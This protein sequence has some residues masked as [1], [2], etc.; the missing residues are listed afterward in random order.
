MNENYKRVFVAL[1]DQFGDQGI[2]WAAQKVAGHFTASPAALAADSD[3]DANPDSSPDANAPHDES[4]F[5]AP[6]D[7]AR[8]LDGDAFV[9]DTERSV[10]G[11]AADAINSPQQV[12]D[13]VMR[14]VMIAGE[15]RKF[16]EAQVTKRLS[17]AADRDVAIAQLKA[18]HQLLQDYL[19]RS[20]D[21]RA[22]NFTKLFAVVD[23]ALDTNNM[24]A[25]ALGLESVVRLATSSPFKDLSNVK[26]TA[27][28]LAN[29]DHE[30]SF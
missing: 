7:D 18:E 3:A 2:A 16:E 15:V 1:Y 28:A 26:E 20:F 11:I 9:A 29:P 25:L 23:T 14:L 27:A 24:E 12:A 4:S 5:E 8:Y 22:D 21:E 10:R 30:W 13:A 19:D 6:A 17:I